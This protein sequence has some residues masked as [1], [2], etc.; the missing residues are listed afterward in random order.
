MKLELIKT[1]SDFS[2]IIN[3]NKVSNFLKNPRTFEE[4]VHYGTTRWQPCRRYNLR[5]Y[6][7][8]I[9]NGDFFIAL[10]DKNHPIFL[11]DRVGKTIIDF[12]NKEYKDF[13]YYNYLKNYP[14]IMNY[15]IR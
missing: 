9:H 6:S 2:K 12:D 15:I 8:K 11:I 1:F 5:E 13:E 14:D 7:E 4:I 3:N 10:N